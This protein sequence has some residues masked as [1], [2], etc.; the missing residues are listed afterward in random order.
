M[1]TFTFWFNSI[2]TWSVGTQCDAAGMWACNAWDTLLLLKGIIIALGMIG[3][4]VAFYV[5]IICPINLYKFMA[6]GDSFMKHFEEE[7]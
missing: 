2:F 7:V 5:S 3:W 4:L 1:F 6:A